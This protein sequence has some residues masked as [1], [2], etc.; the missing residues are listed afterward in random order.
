MVE[1]R[2]TV[3]TGPMPKPTN[4]E[5]DHRQAVG[6]AGSVREPLGKHCDGNY[7]PQSPT[8]GGHDAVGKVQEGEA[9]LGEGTQKDACPE[10]NTSRDADEAGT[11]V[12]EQ[13]AGGKGRD[14]EHKDRDEESDIHACDA[15]AVVRGER[16]PKDAPRV[17]RTEP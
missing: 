11:D 6:E 14:T 2:G 4:A 8:H 16:L 3:I 12:P 9:L 1:M 17:Q 10:E 15:R 13:E 7:V 5:A